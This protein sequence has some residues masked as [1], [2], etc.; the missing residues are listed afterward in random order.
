M[1]ESLYV[2]LCVDLDLLH[3]CMCVSGDIKKS[4]I[5]ALTLHLPATLFSFFF[6]YI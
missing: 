4:N 6:E 2:S 5:K 1:K 3:I